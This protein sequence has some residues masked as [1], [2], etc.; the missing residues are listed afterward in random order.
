[1]FFGQNFGSSG[2]FRPLQ[3]ASKHLFCA[4]WVLQSL[5]LSLS[6]EKERKQSDLI[7]YAPLRGKNVEW[8][9][10]SDC[11][12]CA[13]T[14]DEFPTHPTS[15]SLSLFLSLSLTHSLSVPSSCCSTSLWFSN[16]N[17]IFGGVKCEETTTPSS[18]ASTTTTTL[19]TT[20]PT[21]KERSAATTTIPGSQN[22]KSCWNCG[23]NWLTFGLGLCYASL[24]ADLSLNHSV[25][26]WYRFPKIIKSTAGAGG[27]NP[28]AVAMFVNHCPGFP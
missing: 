13:S 21:T 22:L 7:G 28:K 11:R 17:R 9:K 25:A 18:S 3:V 6:R 27:S 12:K 5:S 19:T 15:L 16:L 10:K 4:F 8:G 14:S 2:T 20:L 23:P 1:M 24:P 26:S